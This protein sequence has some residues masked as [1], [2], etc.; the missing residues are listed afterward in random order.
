MQ[1]EVSITATEFELSSAHIAFGQENT[2]I[3]LM[4]AKSPTLLYPKGKKSD[5]YLAAE[6]LVYQNLIIMAKDAFDT[7]NI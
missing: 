2:S 4:G 3:I 7:D 1:P 6:L 5:A